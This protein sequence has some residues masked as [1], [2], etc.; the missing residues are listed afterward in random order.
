MRIINSSLPRPYR[1][2]RGRRSGTGTFGGL[3]QE[4]DAISK[5][6]GGG[7]GEVKTEV[8]IES[9]FQRSIETLFDWINKELDTSR[10]QVIFRT[11]APVHFR[12]Y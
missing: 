8:S 4:G 10:T 11:Y 3:C 2:T 5:K 1:R 6:W 7:G 12:N 9:A